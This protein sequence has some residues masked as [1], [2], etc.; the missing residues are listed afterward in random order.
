MEAENIA[1]LR[2]RLVITIVILYKVNYS[3]FQKTFHSLFDAGFGG[4]TK[5]ITL[6]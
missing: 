4:A 5:R 1:L 6:S 3:Q 2:G